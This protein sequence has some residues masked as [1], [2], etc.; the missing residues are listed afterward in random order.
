MNPLDST[1]LTDEECPKPSTSRARTPSPP[2]RQPSQAEVDHIKTSPDRE[3]PPDSTDLSD[4]ECPNPS[5]ERART[6]S[7][8]PSRQSSQVP[9]DITTNMSSTASTY[10][11]QS[12]PSSGRRS[13]P[14]TT[15][16][17]SNKNHYNVRKLMKKPRLDIE[18]IHNRDK[19]NHHIPQTLSPLC[20]AIQ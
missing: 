3:N 6:P 20:P 18:K 5:A 7:P 17:P 16:P 2:S 11:G 12:P 1:A 10:G 4:K 13:R 14:S 19:S 8:P 15:S 9:T